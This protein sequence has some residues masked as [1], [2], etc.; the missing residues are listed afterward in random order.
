[1]HVAG[2]HG[3]VGHVDVAVAHGHQGQVLLARG[4]AAGREL[5]D[6]AARRGFRHLAAGVGVDLGVEHQD[7]DVAAGGQ[8]VVESAVA[9]VVGPAVAAE[10]PDALL[11]Q[12]VGDAEQVAGFG[13]VDAGELLLQIWRRGRAARRCR[14][15]SS[16][17]R[18]G[19]PAPV[20][21]RSAKPSFQPVRGH[22]R[23]ACRRPAACRGRT[24]HCLRTASWS[25][26][27]RPSCVAAVGSGGQ[28]AAVDG[29]AAGGVGDE[30]AVAE[31]LRHQLDVRG[32]AAAGAGAG[33]LEQRLQQ[34][35]V[36]HL[37]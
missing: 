9:D 3:D 11:D 2:A 36:L 32:F 18:R 24:R 20:P 15:R 17:R 7:V 8:H 21:R 30:R 6:R 13:R 23:S 1:M 28:V 16:G 12:G 26:R 25:R 22:T 19:W 5:G 27:P 4:L 29:G 14:L 33:E 31:Q 10:D 34:L 37:G 35:D